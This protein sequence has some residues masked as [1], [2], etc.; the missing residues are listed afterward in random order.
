[1]KTGTKAQGQEHMGKLL[2]HRHG[3]GGPKRGAD[4]EERAAERRVRR[5]GKKACQDRE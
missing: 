2:A 3:N 1:M 4:R 5:A